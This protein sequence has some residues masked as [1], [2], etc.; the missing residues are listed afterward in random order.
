MSNEH[1]PTEPDHPEDELS[2]EEAIGQVATALKQ[3]RSPLFVGLEKLSTATQQSVM[4]LARA[5]GATTD[6]SGDNIGRGNMFALQKRGRVTAT[7]GEIKSR[8]NL[9]VFWFCDPVADHDDFFERYVGK[10]CETIVVASQ[11]NA[12]SQFANHHIELSPEQSV[13]AIWAMR[14]QVKKV[15]IPCSANLPGGIRELADQL[16]TSHYGALIWGSEHCDAEFDLQADG[17]HAMVRE[18]NQLTRFVSIPYRR[19]ANG[20][21]AENVS[22]WT[23]GFP[24]AVNWNRPQPRQYWLEYSNLAMSSRNEW[25]FL[26]SFDIGEVSITSLGN[27]PGQAFQMRLPVAEF[28]IDEGGDACRFDDVSITLPATE[29]S[30]SPTT[31]EIVT[32]IF[33]ALS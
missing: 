27:E 2:L 5:A 6:S 16:A 32:S 18:L 28:G 8:S 11:P 30:K 19:D 25:D 13:Q 10:D 23:S 26:L 22:T 29:A 14:A 9:I 7:L 33:E 15:E 31:N 4:R 12:T 24:F 1:L 20:L 3:S 21:S 17:I